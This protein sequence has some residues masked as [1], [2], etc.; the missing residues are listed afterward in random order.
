MRMSVVVNYFTVL[1]I[2]YYVQREECRCAVVNGVEYVLLR[3]DS[4]ERV[5]ISKSN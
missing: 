5:L 1:Q 4:C 3:I 2:L